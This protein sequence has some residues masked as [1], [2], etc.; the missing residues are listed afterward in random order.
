MTYKTFFLNSS[1][2]SLQIKNLLAVN[3]FSKTL[4]RKRFRQSIPSNFL[5]TVCIL[6]TNSTLFLKVLTLNVA[7]T[8][9]FFKKKVYSHNKLKNLKIK[10]FFFSEKSFLNKTPLS[11][12]LS[13]VKTLNLLKIPQLTSVVHP[14]KG[15]YKV[16]CRGLIGF[17]PKSHY[18]VY[19]FKKINLFKSGCSLTVRI[20]SLK[21]IKQHYFRYF[22]CIFFA[23][24]LLCV[25][26]KASF[27]SFFQRQKY[28]HKQNP[29]QYLTYKLAKRGFTF[30]FIFL[31]PYLKNFFVK[32]H[33]PLRYKSSLKHLSV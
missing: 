9:S 24:K 12:F 32:N 14:L 18:R 19:F 16:F 25:V 28:K 26:G 7:G 29:K 3:I 11:L 13:S 1:K 2:T 6:D 8:Y 31:S 30:K 23:C 17:L 22:L 20:I 4:I 33:K 27:R 10:S 5:G 15:G 21:L